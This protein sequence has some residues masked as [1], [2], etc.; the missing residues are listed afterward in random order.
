MIIR[1][2]VCNADP[3]G[4]WKSPPAMIF[5]DP[6]LEDGSKRDDFVHACRDHLSE[7]REKE[8]QERGPLE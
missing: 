6:Y 5:R 1:C 2:N 3:T 4:R 7:K 8:I